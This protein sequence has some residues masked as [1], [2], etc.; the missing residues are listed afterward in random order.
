MVGVVHHLTR[1]YA[2]W[3]Y[4]DM[5]T[6]NYNRPYF[7]YIDNMRRELNRSSAQLT[8]GVNRL[9]KPKSSWDKMAEIK[10]TEVEE[11]TL[12]EILDLSGSYMELTGKWLGIFMDK[13]KSKQ[14]KKL[15]EQRDEVSDKLQKASDVLVASEAI[16][17]VN[18]RKVGVFDW[19]NLLQT[20]FQQD[21]VE[22]LFEIADEIFTKSIKKLEDGLGSA[23]P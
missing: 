19:W 11:R 20:N 3:R 23:R 14:R 2:Y 13:G 12:F 21:G 5:T 9:N 8:D 10:L 22:E 1:R 6:M 18:G 16:N 15:L 17:Q 7:R 4:R